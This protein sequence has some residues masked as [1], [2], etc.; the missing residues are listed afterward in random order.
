M[1]GR[2]TLRADAETIAQTFEL[3]EAPELSPRYNIAPT[4]PAPIVLTTGGNAHR[5]FRT[6][7]WGLIPSWAKDAVIGFG[8]SEETG[9]GKEG[10]G[11]SPATSMARPSQSSLHDETR[12]V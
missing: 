12:S 11:L 6:L 2:F 7:R 3:N 1:C 8:G 10:G 9:S 5:E 4:Q